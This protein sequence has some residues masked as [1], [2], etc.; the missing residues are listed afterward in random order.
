MNHFYLWEHKPGAGQKLPRKKKKR[1]RKG[2]AQRFLEV[3]TRSFR[4]TEP[5]DLGLLQAP[6]LPLE[7]AKVLP[8]LRKVPHSPAAPAAGP[9]AGE[10]RHGPATPPRTDTGPAQE[11]Y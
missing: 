11:A 4:P 2:K 1:E 7:Q 5:S 9:P 3:T 10:A 6:L 8:P